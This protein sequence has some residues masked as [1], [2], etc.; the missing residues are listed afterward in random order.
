MLA[1]RHGERIAWGLGWV[2]IHVPELSPTFAGS[3]RN[4]YGPRHQAI[5]MPDG[6]TS[7]WDYFSDVWWLR[8]HVGRDT[9]LV[10]ASNGKNDGGIGW[11][12]AWQ[13]ARALQETR[14]PHFFNWALDGHGTRTRVGSSFDVDVRTDQS[15]PA[16]TQCSL[17]DDLGTATPKNQEQ[18]EA[19]KKRQEAEV[20]AGK[21]REVVVDPFDGDSVGQYNA[22]LSWQTDDILDR[23]GVWEMT[24]SLSRN[25]PRESCTVAL[26][27]RR[28]QKFRSPTGKAFRWFNASLG[29]GKVIQSGRVTSD[30]WGLITLEK[31]VVA[32]SKNRIQI[33]QE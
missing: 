23:P 20:K 28:C 27:P 14:R 22:F 25:A 7:P 32:K 13:F 9:G 15:L 26:T 33:S 10:I 19:E 31:L 4:S 8:N 29:D 11:P 21:R 16:F 24:V 1:L 5:T 12:Q 18:I 3:Y 2:G 17:D 30:G 6:K